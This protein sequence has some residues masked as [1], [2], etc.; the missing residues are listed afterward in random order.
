MPHV[1][2][3]YIFFYSRVQLPID[4]T[5]EFLWSHGVYIKEA[6]TVAA[7]Q[8]AFFGTFFQLRLF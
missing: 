7:V 1:L 5:F 8:H 6:Q 3:K 4:P 2:P